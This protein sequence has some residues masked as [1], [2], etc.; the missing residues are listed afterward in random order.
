MTSAAFALSLDQVRVA[1]IGL[2]YVGLPLSVAMGGRFPT[3]GFDVNAARV[4]ALQGGHDHTGEV[5][6]AAITAARHLTFSADIAAIADCNVYIV[7]VPT[8]VDGYHQ[9]DLAPLIA[10]S[11]TVGQVIAPGDVVIYESTVYPG[12]TEEDCIP[13]VEQR[14][15]LT[16]NRDFFAGYS[17][18]RINPGDKARPLTAIRKIT[19]GSTPAVADF[20]DALYASVITAGTYKAST[21]RVAEAAKVIENT[22]RDVNIALI[23]QLAMTLDQLGIDTTEVLDAAATK[24]NFINL[25]PGLVGGHCIGVDPYYLLHKSS[26]V[27]YIPDIVRRAREIN[28][29]MAAHAALMLVRSMI[30]RGQPVRG[31][32]VLVEGFTFKENCSDIRNTKVVDLL[33]ALARY[34][35]HC[36]LTDAW[37]D[38]A[39]AQAEYGVT[40]TADAAPGAMFDAVILAVPHAQAVARGAAHYRGLL[41]PGGV[42]FDLKAVFARADSDLRL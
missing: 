6:S 28:D 29:G 18:E 14:S 9:P 17:P 12:A 22:Q 42:F 25:R 23:N 10:A 2:G 1:V 21:I 15:G 5:E 16:Y 8:P 20:V 34:G 38:P 32:R 31:A 41:T 11:G 24:W 26:S 40:L 37:A 39:E 3:V 30:G 7:A 33:A 19:S 35:M 13:V 36:T 4:A 27:G